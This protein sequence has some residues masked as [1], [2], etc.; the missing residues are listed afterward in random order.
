MI[1]RASIGVTIVTVTLNTAACSSSD[2]EHAARESAAPMNRPPSD[3]ESNRSEPPRGEPAAPREEPRSS[4]MIDVESPPGRIDRN[5]AFDV[6]HWDTTKEPRRTY[7]V[8]SGELPPGVLLTGHGTLEGTPTTSG[9]HE[10]VL[11]GEGACGDASCRLEV[12]LSVPVP[13]VILLSGFGP[14][15][16]VPVNP[17]WQ[18]VEPLNDTMIAGYDVRV[19]QVPVI[20]NEA[21]PTYFD[22]YRRLNPSIALASG[23]A[24]GETGIRVETT[25]RNYANG[26]DVDN[27]VWPTGRIDSSGPDTYDTGLP[28]DLLIGALHQANYPTVLSDNA[29]EYLCNFLFYGLMKR[30]SAETPARNVI[31]GFVHVPGPEVVAPVDM[32]AA[33]RMMIT[34]LVAHREQLVANHDGLQRPNARAAMVPIVH[35]APRYD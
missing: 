18:A 16:G 19:I 32:T 11:Y 25:A 8:A 12:H 34:R 3:P 30:M 22:A 26:S 15:A 14:F 24:M 9:H 2:K 5:Y 1:R 28:V 21:L 13:N 6:R 31:A 7:H 20:W 33:W 10:A 23:V 35:D 17:S 4:L 29:G 27:V